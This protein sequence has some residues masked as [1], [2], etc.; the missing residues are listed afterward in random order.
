MNTVNRSMQKIPGREL[1]RGRECLDG[2]K[3]LEPLPAG[4]LL[5]M[6]K[7]CFIKKNILKLFGM[8]ARIKQ[9]SM[10]VWRSPKD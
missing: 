9:Y 7:I 5:D 4:N 2:E 1:T 8:W 3:K 10:K 6:T